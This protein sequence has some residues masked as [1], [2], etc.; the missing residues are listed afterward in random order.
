MLI[1]SHQCF[2]VKSPAPA[3]VVGDY[4]ITDSLKMM[5]GMYRPILCLF[6]SI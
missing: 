3:H 6:L 2:N 5:L 1:I 4:V